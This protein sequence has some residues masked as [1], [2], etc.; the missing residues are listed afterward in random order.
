MD[1]ERSLTSPGSIFKPNS[2]VREPVNRG[3]FINFGTCARQVVG[4]RIID[5]KE[6]NIGTVDPQHPARAKQN[7]QQHDHFWHTI[8][9]SK[10]N[11]YLN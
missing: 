7:D 4:S 1:E 10:P 5:K 2:L 6:E 8:H 9:A 3:R 11:P